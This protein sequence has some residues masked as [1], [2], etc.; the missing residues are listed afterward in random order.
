MCL[1]FIPIFSNI[2]YNFVYDTDPLVMRI[3]YQKILE[4]TI[5]MSQQKYV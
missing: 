4:P 3:Y 5:S 2:F 1:G